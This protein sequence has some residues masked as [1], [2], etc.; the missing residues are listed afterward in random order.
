MKNFGYPAMLVVLLLALLPGAALAH[1]C[2]NPAQY[3]LY[4]GQN[5]LVGVV[6]VCNDGNSLTVAYDTSSSGWVI[7]ETHL[8]VGDQ[9]RDIPQ[10]KTGNPIPGKFPYGGYFNPPVTTVSYTVPK[11]AIGPIGV[12]STVFIA[13]HAVVWNPTNVGTMQ[14]CSDGD[15]IYTAYNNA[16]LGPDPG[17]SALDGRTGTAYRS[18]EPYGE[19]FDAAPSVWDLG[20]DAPFYS[21]S[22]A[23]SCADWIWERNLMEVNGVVI[24]QSVNPVHGDRVEF[25]QPFNIPGPFA[26]G[27]LYASCDNGY[28][29]YVN[30]TTPGAPLIQGQVAGDWWNSNLY[31]PYVNTN[32]W[33]SVESAP[34]TGLVQGPNFLF[35]RTANEYMDSDDEFNNLPGNS[36]VSMIGID[37]GFKF[38]P[39][40]YI[41][42]AGLIFQADI[43][44]YNHDETAWAA[45]GPGSGANQFPGKNWATYITYTWQ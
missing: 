13:A 37:P 24:N 23:P 3:P 29:A 28:E 20:V 14:V 7:T 6:T 31:E 45:Q 40:A 25:M 36:P 21:A 10:T 12:G 32:G 1:Q 18:A 41:N 43:S 4:A 35:F 5:I 19:Q 22:G 8:A 16:V 38:L 34:L 44:Y 30:T 15:E 2:D 42:P 9:L 27:M 11:S 33:Q 26:S 39:D 17:S